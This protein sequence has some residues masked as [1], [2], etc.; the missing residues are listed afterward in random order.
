[1]RHPVCKAICLVLA[2]VC[3]A[4]AFLFFGCTTYLLN[5]GLYE[6]TPAGLLESAYS[7]RAEALASNVAN[8]YA[9]GTFSKVPEYIL[10]DIS[11]PYDNESISWR[12]D[13]DPDN[14]YYTL[15]S[16]DGQALETNAPKDISSLR[17]YEVTVRGRYL[18][19]SQIP[20]QAHV[21]HSYGDTTWYLS[22]ADSPEYQVT[23]YLRPNSVEAVYGM[24]LPVLELLHS[25]RYTVIV[26]CG[27]MLLIYALC[28][29]LLCVAAGRR[30]K[31]EQP[32]PGGL[33][34]LPLDVY[35]AGAGLACFFLVGLSLELLPFHDMFYYYTD[36]VDPLL[37]MKLAASG[38]L[39]FVAAFLAT[40]FLFALAAQCKARDGYWWRNCV[41]FRLLRLLYKA[42]RLCA[43]NVLRLYR[44][45]PLIWQ[46]LVT[47]FGMG[48]LLLLSILMQSEFLLA[49]SLLACV[50]VVLYGAWAYGQLLKGAQQMAQ[51]NLRAKVSTKYL[52]GAFRDLA[53]DLNALSDV[54]LEAADVRLRSE[55]MKAEL[56][57]NVSHDIKT[58]LTSIIN[59][60][61][62]LPRAQDEQ[63]KQEYLSILDRQSQR[64][65]R[66]IEDLTEMSRASTGN[67]QTNIAPMDAVEGI[68]Q[69][70]GEFSDKLA[71][72]QLQVCTDLPEEPVMIEADGRLFWR[73]MSNLLSNVVKYA[74]PGTRFYVRLLRGQDGVQIVLKNI[75]REPLTKD[76]RELT[77]RFVRGD[78]SRNTEGSGLGLSIA[79]SLMDVQKG[80]LQLQVDAD[81][82][83]AI[84]TFPIAQ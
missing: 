55:R 68:T 3:L 81:L 13:I 44:M 42:L 46:W 12:V 72:A 23:V 63:Q 25:H 78:T 36:R 65:K 48:L 30:R 35:L 52:I 24:E 2:A 15:S 32:H 75:S 83:T 43:R 17:Q 84:L 19:E 56:I 1:M 77:E 67:I 18:Q 22:Y 79:G 59:Y 4:S 47:G 53:E 80:S 82:F 20:S 31:E 39:L 33:N 69:A 9:E 21:I 62:L 58:P 73:V 16:A 60:I 7:N 14:W 66:L 57:T 51:G 45:L 61:D 29:V 54:T 37:H 38:G 74:M 10:S 5:A 71:L 70:L 11:G 49:L 64:L 28:L 41:I 6:H 27:V 26:M 76:A 34:R 50:T 8:R 40:A